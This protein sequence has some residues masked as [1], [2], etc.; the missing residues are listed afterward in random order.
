[1]FQ[2]GVVE[3]AATGAGVHDPCALADHAE[4]LAGCLLVLADHH[5]GA[6]AHVLLLA[7]DL[8]HAL[9]AVVGEGFLGVF[10]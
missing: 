8:R 3:E 6:G 10:E 2:I 4:A 5:H 7:D 9:V 1:M